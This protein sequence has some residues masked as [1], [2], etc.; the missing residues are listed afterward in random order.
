MVRERGDD[1]DGRPSWFDRNTWRAS[2]RTT[3]LTPA[4]MRDQSI[5][6]VLPALDEEATVGRLVSA[7][8]PLTEGETPLIDELVV[9][10]SGSTDR[11]RERAREAG[12]RV[13]DRHDVLPGIEVRPGKGEALWRAVAATSGELVVFLDSDLVDTDP[14]ALVTGLLEPLLA[15]PSVQLVKGC[16]RRPLRIE[17]ETTAEGGGRV[18]ELLVR[19]LLAALHPDLRWIIQPLGGEY[20]ARR[21]L[22]ES[23]PFAAGYGVEIGLLVDTLAHHGLDA[24]AQVD[25]GVRKHRNRSVVELGVMARQVLGALLRRTGSGV[26]DLGEAIVQFE[27]AAGDWRPVVTEV[28]DGDRPPLTAIGVDAVAGRHTGPVQPRST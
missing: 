28:D 8:H 2:D 9:M 18:T 1:V 3:D 12:A 13:L 19:P 11:T 25:L 23:L 5:S 14:V 7:L 21:E 20:A 24:I 10:D 16:Y 27:R 4:A 22:L 26:A 17:S 15:R 6:V